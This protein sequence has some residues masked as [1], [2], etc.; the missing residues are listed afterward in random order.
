MSMEAITG[1]LWIFFIIFNLVI[2]HKIFKVYYFNLGRGLMK[3]LIASIFFA[4]IETAI[5]LRIGKYV[6]IVIGIILVI[7]FIV[8]KFGQREEEKQGQ[9]EQPD[10]QSVK[11]K[12]TE[13][14]HSKEVNTNSIEPITSKV[15]ENED[16]ESTNK[17][18]ISEAMK[19]IKEKYDSNNKVE[20]IKEFRKL[21]GLGL[22]ESKEIIDQILSSPSSKSVFQEPEVTQNVMKEHEEKKIYCAHCGEKILLSAKF[23]N[24]CG[25]ANSYKK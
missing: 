16:I 23:C 25:E 6:L 8:M 13:E 19:I 4:S 22:K 9:T 12:S 18:P 10:A 24:Y 21:T 14:Q 7:G 11:P 15:T 17:I 5:A 2:Y 3:E 20:A 1:I